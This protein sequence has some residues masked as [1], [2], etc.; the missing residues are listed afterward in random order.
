M[1]GRSG[2]T[3]MEVLVS[4]V[5]MALVIGGLTALVGGQL[6]LLR[7][8]E[9]HVLREHVIEQVLKLH[10]QELDLLP[11]EGEWEGHPWTLSVR[12]VSPAEGPLG[13]YELC[14]ETGGRRGCVRVA[15]PR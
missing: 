9:E 6:R 1:K 5:I 7:R 2:F 12:D 14:V 13:L 10:L 15:R 3:L 11:D 4:V 8:A